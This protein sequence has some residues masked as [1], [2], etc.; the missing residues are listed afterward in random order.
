ML[1]SRLVNV[2]V[3]RFLAAAFLSVGYNTPRL[4]FNFDEYS[5]Q[6]HQEVGYDVFGY[7]KFLAEDDAADLIT[8]HVSQFAA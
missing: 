3:N 2:H 8:K 4:N 1:L 5:K 7:M 6:L